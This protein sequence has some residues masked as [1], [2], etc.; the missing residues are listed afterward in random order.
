MTQSQLAAIIDLLRTSPLDMGGDPH[1]MRLVFDEMIGSHPVPEDVRAIAVELGGVDTIEVTA[2]C[3]KPSGAV[4]YF[5][6]G[7]YALGSAAAGVNL[8]ADVARR[9]GTTVHAVDYRLAP[10]NP[11]PA[12]VDD[13]VAAYRGLLDRG[14]P[15]GS[16]AVTGE[17]AG[18]GLALALLV[19]IKEAGLPRP[20]AAAV[21]SPW[22]DL[23]QSGRSYETKAVLD[24]ALTRQALATRADDYL[25]GADPRSPFASPLF[26]DLRGLP[27]LLIQA[28][29][30]EVLLDDALRLAAKAADDDVAVVL[31]TFPGAP[32]VFQGFSAV[33]AEGAQALDQV[34]TFLRTH[35][36][37]QTETH[38]ASASSGA[39]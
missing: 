18:G 3:D 32:H 39:V 21:L 14:I 9:T 2:G 37:Q 16:I 7:G 1:K 15:A 22:A 25:A 20:T 17:S 31:Q 29:T 33:L 11:F 35:L 36:D 28:G 5:H 10:E 23:T 27:P 4:L 26:A 8:A 30:Y 19:A 13:A 24:P 38:G 12:A 6:G 34:G